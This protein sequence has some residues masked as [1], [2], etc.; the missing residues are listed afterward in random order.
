M[1]LL[2]KP[3]FNESGFDGRDVGASPVDDLRLIRMLSL[4]N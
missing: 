4:F 1:K 3:D 2:K